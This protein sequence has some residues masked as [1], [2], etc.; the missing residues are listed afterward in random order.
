MTKC[1]KSTP[2]TR[3]NNGKE[4]VGIAEIPDLSA[5]RILDLDCH[6]LPERLE[7]H[8]GFASCRSPVP[9]R[10]QAL[11]RTRIRSLRRNRHHFGN[12]FDEPARRVQ[13]Y[14]RPCLGCLESVSHFED[15]HDP[16]VRAAATETVRD[17]YAQGNAPCGLETTS[18]FSSN[19]R[20]SPWQCGVLVR[21]G[22][23]SQLEFGSVHR[24]STGH[25]DG[26]LGS[27]VGPQSPSRDPSKGWMCN[28]NSRTGRARAL[29]YSLRPP[30][31]ETWRP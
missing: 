2:G 28:L 20:L 27:L 13:T 26:L 12:L 4:V 30:P 5:A 3:R 17:G 29:Y 11:H 16:S 8:A 21:L 10:R 22:L 7:R 31:F 25:G 19:P 1:G 23:A 9:G 14:R 6:R 18:S 15:G 24:V